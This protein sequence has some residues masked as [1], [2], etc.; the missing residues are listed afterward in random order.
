MD[1]PVAV[2][3]AQPADAPGIVELCF[4]V[5]TIHAEA[6][7]DWFLPDGRESVDDLVERMNAPDHF[8]WVAER[9]G[10]LVGCAIARLNEKP[11]NRWCYASREL[12]LEHIGVTPDHQRTGVGGLLWEAVRQTA[13][14]ENVQRVTLSVWSFNKSARDFYVE[15]GFVPLHE[16]LAFEL[17]QE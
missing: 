10:E 12:S 16:R 6:R 14:D 9:G 3:R 17:P 8:L 4:E 2:R 11:R 13:L 5:Q 1:N 15:A 7:P